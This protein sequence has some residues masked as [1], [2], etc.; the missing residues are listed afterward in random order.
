MLVAV[1]VAL[2]VVSAKFAT[3]SCCREST[4][5]SV[6]YTA[7][8]HCQGKVESGKW[9]VESGK[10]NAD[11]GRLMQGRIGGKVQKAGSR[12]R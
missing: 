8:E 1:S 6:S 11:A 3:V 4:E 2:E 12:D 10:W 5:V 9:K 7:K